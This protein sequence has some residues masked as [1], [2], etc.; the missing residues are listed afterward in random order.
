M[1]CSV[2]LKNTIY[3]IQRLSGPRNWL[4]VCGNL[5]GFKKA[6]TCPEPQTEPDLGSGSGFGNFSKKPDRT[7]HRQHY[8][9]A[10]YSPRR[11]RSEMISPS[12]IALIG[13]R[14][15]PHV[16]SAREAAPPC[17]R[18]NN[19]CTPP[20]TLARLRVSVI[21]TDTLY[22][23]AWRS[24]NL[25]LPPSGTRTTHPPPTLEPTPCRPWS[26]ISDSQIQAHTSVHHAALE[27]D[28]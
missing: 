3:S 14:Y 15:T 28:T 19:Q 20:H 8:W 9:H 27:V 10:Q 12:T 25:P 18:M 21:F 16:Q 24:Q 13:R 17:M 23:H 11:F 1:A 4:L 6:R 22:E 5:F 2:E 26:M 7:G